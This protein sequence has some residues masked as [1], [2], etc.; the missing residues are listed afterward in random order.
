M[1]GTNA[2]YERDGRYINAPVWP[3]LIAGSMLAALFVLF[4]LLEY[5][6]S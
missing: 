3:W 5:Y 4:V 1:H 2:P 6:F